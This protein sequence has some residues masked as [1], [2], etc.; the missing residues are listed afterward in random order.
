MMGNLFKATKHTGVKNNL[1]IVL[2]PHIIR[3]ASDLE[4]FYEE[5]KDEMKKIQEESKARKGK[6]GR[7]IDIDQYLK[8]PAP[9]REGESE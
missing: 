3:T 5:K 4:G 6:E 2:T 9:V 7:G 1:L 8:N